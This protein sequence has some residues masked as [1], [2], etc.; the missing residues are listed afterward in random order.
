MMIDYLKPYELS[1]FV[2]GILG[3]IFIFQLLV[4]DVAAIAAKHTPGFPVIPNHNNFFF[5]ATRAVA[6]SNESVSIFVLLLIFGIF[7]GAQAKWLNISVSIYLLGRIAHM[8]CYYFDLKSA[9]SAGFIVALIGLLGMF[10]VG[11][12]S[13][14][15]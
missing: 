8:F 13:W 4:A 6:N 11:I 10:S 5:R 12:Y 7:S 9:R 3:L 14:F 15:Q 2:T 1:I